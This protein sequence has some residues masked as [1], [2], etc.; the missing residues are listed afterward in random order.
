MSIEAENVVGIMGARH[1]TDPEQLRGGVVGVTGMDDPDRTF[2]HRA[3]TDWGIDPHSEIEFRVLG[4]RG[5]VWDAMVAGE[6]LA[7]A[8]TIPQ[9]LLARRLGLPVLRDFHDEHEVYQVGTIVTS[10]RFADEQPEALRAF[11]GAARRSIE[12]FQSDFELSL[13]HLKARSKLDDVD[14]LRE[15][16]RLFSEA[17]ADYVPKVEAIAAVARDY[18]AATGQPVELDFDALVDAS[19][20]PPR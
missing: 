5:K 14:V 10:R 1:I 15:T 7:M 18:A 11:L 6:V 4:T 13:P 3:L 2:L 19:F 8:A 17:M 9:P 16:H 12:L 20:V